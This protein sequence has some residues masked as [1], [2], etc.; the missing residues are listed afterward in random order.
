MLADGAAVDAVYR[1]DGGVLDGVHDGLVLL[2]MSTVE[3]QVSRALAPEVAARGGTLLD[4]PVSG[5]TA[6]ADAGQLTLMIGGDAAALE[7]VRPV[8]EALATRVFHLG[9]VGTGAA[10][11]L[12]V[13]AVVFGLDVAL[14]E[15]LVLAERAG[16]GRVQAWD[17][18]QA[19]AVGA[20]FVG[21]KR[22]NFVEPESAPTLFSLDLAAKDLALITALGEAVGVPVA[23]ARTNL[24]LMRRSA[25]TQGGERD[26]ALVA[27]HLRIQGTA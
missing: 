14:S 5:S 7:R 19:S 9:P 17:V 6:L 16:V 12:A 13:N 15:A 8:V 21:Y 23:Q 27:A 1:A 2:D 10:M 22:A 4:A 18:F 25:A 3:P 24:D 11:K 20:P 26:F